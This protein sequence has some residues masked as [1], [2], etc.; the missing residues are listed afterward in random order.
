MH[1]SL[2]L[3]GLPDHAEGSEGK[4][5]ASGPEKAG[6]ERFHNVGALIIRIGF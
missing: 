2:P 3:T 6:D 5:E 1:S 4:E